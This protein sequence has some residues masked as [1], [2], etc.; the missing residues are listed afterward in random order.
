MRKKICLF[1][2]CCLFFVN[3]FA[4]QNLLQA[5]D[6]KVI[7]LFGIYDS[8]G[9]DRTT[10]MEMAGDSLYDMGHAQILRYYGFDSTEFM[11]ALDAHN[12][13]VVQT[14]GS[15]PIA[16]LAVKDGH[17]SYVTTT[18]IN[19]TYASNALSQMRIC[20]IGACSSGAGGVTSNNIVNSIY[21]KG[22]ECVIGYSGTVSTKHNSMMLKNFCYYISL[23]Y[24]VDDAL[25]MAQTAVFARYGSYGNIDQR[26]VRGDQSISIT[27]PAYEYLS[28]LQNERTCISRNT[29]LEMENCFDNL[30]QGY[31]FESSQNST[32]LTK[33]MRKYINDIKTNDV[34]FYV[35]D[36]KGNM[37]TS[38][39]PRVG[40]G[41]SV[42]LNCP[43]LYE[44]DILAYV[45]ANYGILEVNDIVIDVE[46]VNN[47]YV[48]VYYD[49]N[50]NGI[51]T[52]EVMSI[53]LNE[54]V[55]ER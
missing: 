12:M 30:E 40:N 3:I 24:Q 28:A 2:G 29:V 35:L 8:D 25:S 38:G 52:L 26:L 16:I 18:I 53:A 11:D 48:D 50:E 33:C 42:A 51:P 49:T 6:D 23:G 47:V 22:A 1:I 13:L 9:A 39:S 45:Q 27:E 55:L 44:C 34:V 54:I 46:D 4:S 17:E 20:F 37:L 15:G 31:R 5:Y 7:S 43:D 36:T 32:T 21:G 14:H 10:W 19:S 41:E